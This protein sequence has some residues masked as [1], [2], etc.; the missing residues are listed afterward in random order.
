MF[1]GNNLLSDPRYKEFCETFYDDCL[2]YVLY[3]SRHC[4][5]WQQYEVLKLISEPGARVAIPSGHGCFGKGTEV[6]MFDGSIKRVEDVVVGDVL[7]GDDNKPRKVLDLKRGRERL[8]K[9]EFMDA[10]NGGTEHIY[11]ESHTMCL[12]ATQTHGLQEKGDFAEITVKDWLNWSDR[13]KRTHAIYRRSCD[14]DKKF[15]HVPPYI[16]GIWLGDGSSNGRGITNPDQE[17]IDEL[18]VFCESEGCS[19]ANDGNIYHSIRGRRHAVGE[20]AFFDGLKHYGLINNKH[21][22]FDY[23]TSCRDDRLNLLAGLLDTDGYLNNPGGMVFEI[24]QKSETLA[25]QIVFL[26]RS[27][28]FHSSVK[29]KIKNCHYKGQ[30]IPGEYS[31][32]SI[33]RGIEAIPN[34]VKRKQADTECDF[35]RSNLHFG[36]RNCECIGEGDYYGFTVD[37]NSRFLG[38]DF[39][40][41]HNCGKSDLSARIFDWHM[42]VFPFSNALLTANNVEQCRA[43]IWKYLDDAIAD[44]DRAFPWMKGFFVKEAKRYYARPYKDSWYVIPKT[45]SKDKPE[46]LSGQHSV[47]YLVIID[48]ASSVADANIDVIE[49]AFTHE[50]NRCMMSSQPTRPVGRFAEYIT[51]QAKKITPEGRVEGR[52]DVVEMNSEDSPLVTRNFIRECMIKYG[53]HHSPEYMIKCLGRLPDNLSGYLIPKSWCEQSQYVTIEHLE[54]WG[55]VLTVDVAEG[56]HRDSSVATMGKVSGH[57]NERR[58]EVVWQEEFLDKNEKELAR[59]VAS[60]FRDHKYPALTI[61]VDAD[62]A[63]RTVILDLEEIGIPCE[64]IH[65]GLPCHSTGD[66]KRFINLRAYSHLKLREAIFEERFKGPKNKKWV[67]QASKLPYSLDERGRYKMMPK[68]QMRSE[69]IKSPDLSDTTCF[70]FL[71]DYISSEGVDRIGQVEDDF[72]KLAKEMVG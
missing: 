29:R 20:N 25:N 1:R 8:Y 5:T 41:L 11:N 17:I 69:G 35:Q 68:P 71:V 36:I 28:G 46:G 65:W 19:T 33:S 13:K 23:L 18:N 38:G 4:P 58:V 59:Y 6:L 10:R 31:I 62:G 42:R 64:R 47:N 51:T 3:T 61:A 39:T 66:Q 32:V 40:V 45:A 16:L 57:G 72:L 70:F 63:G 50:R 27:L 22:P 49:G 9:F 30:K 60:I 14:F 55:W 21:I 12:V 52:Y 34:R 7:M 43:V 56:E 2:G 44:A 67:A 54:A 24:T 15:L 48:E 37:G 26:A 53:G